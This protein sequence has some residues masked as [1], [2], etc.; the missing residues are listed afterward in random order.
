VT[1]DI[2]RER[3]LFVKDANLGLF[4]PMVYRFILYLI[5]DVTAAE[6]LT[7]ETFKI[8]LSKGMDEQKGT[9]YG[10]WL[11]SISRNV[12]RNHVRSTRRNRFLLHGN[13]LELAEKKFVSETESSGW[14]LRRDA[15]DGCVSTLTPEE[16]SLLRMR[17]E[18]GISVNEIGL[19]LNIEPNT[20]SKRLQRIRQQLQK[21]IDA[22]LEAES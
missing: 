8:A 22:K 10:A 18:Q 7:Q 21:C 9:D 16:Q 4:E 19:N 13:M 2:S 14:D 5:R 17:Y 6:D 11:R 20:V 15:L 3:K 1:E 12:V